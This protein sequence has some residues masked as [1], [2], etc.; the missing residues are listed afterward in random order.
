MSFPGDGNLSFQN[1]HLVLAILLVHLLEK[2]K[3]YRQEQRSA[4]IAQRRQVWNGRIVRVYLVLP[5]YVDHYVCYVEQQHDL[6][7]CDDQVRGNE[8]GMQG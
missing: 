6:H 7:N 3:R 5:H 4:Q 1:L 2:D 8:V